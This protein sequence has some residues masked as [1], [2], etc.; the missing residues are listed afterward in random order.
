MHYYYYF[1]IGLHWFFVN[2]DINTSITII[3][4]IMVMIIIVIIV[5]ASQEND[6]HSLLRDT[7]S[8]SCDCCFLFTRPR[9]VFV[10]IPADAE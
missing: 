9:S 4:I 1:S 10:H 2:I 5:N 3:I 8:W 6:A 7:L